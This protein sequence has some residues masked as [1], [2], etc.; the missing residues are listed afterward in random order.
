MQYNTTHGFGTHVTGYGTEQERL[1][2]WYT[3]A[4]FREGGSSKSFRVS[5]CALL[6]PWNGV[7]RL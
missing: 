2:L 3:Y 7:G 6:S 4:P 1:K 5:D